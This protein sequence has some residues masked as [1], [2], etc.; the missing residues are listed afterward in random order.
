VPGKKPPLTEWDRRAF[1]G[2][3]GIGS[4]AAGLLGTLLGS[5]AAPLS[6]PGVRGLM[7]VSRRAMACDF[8]LF[9][10]AQY[11]SAVDAGCAAL[12]EIERLEKKLSAYL[13]DSDICRFNAEAY[14]APVTVDQE[15]FNLLDT[16]GRLHRETAGAFDIAA[17]SL[18]KAW[19]FFKDPR[20]VPSEAEL[21][22]ALQSSGMAHVELD[23]SARSVRLLRRGLEVNLGSIG[24]GYA[25]DRAL[26]LVVTGWKPVPR[27]TGFQPVCPVLMHGGQS[28]LKALG[29]PPDE[30]RGWK[31]EIGDPYNSSRR[32][33]SL[34]LKNQALGTSSAAN[35]WFEEGGRRYGHLLD[36]RT[37]RPAQGMAGASVLAP[38]A[39]EADALSTAF[40]VMGIEPARQYCQQH[41]EIGAVLVAEPQAGQAPEAVLLGQVLG[42]A[43]PA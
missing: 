24:K 16:A 15:V 27:G 7:R 43:R 33:A 28:S 1:L 12:D 18:I 36:P 20:R 5:G 22:A 3:E 29:A 6:V 4:Y 40:F 2:G 32:I 38:T 26:E 23:A 9:F 30:P 21:R 42:N 11:A 41:P 39:A 17:G 31:V 8:T 14:D 35:Q 13:A 25:I 34:W 19:G 10:P 37:G